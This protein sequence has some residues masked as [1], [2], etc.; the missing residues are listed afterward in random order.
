MT[1]EEQLKLYNA[2]KEAYYNNGEEI[3][4]DIEFDMLEKEL[5]LEN[6]AYVGARHNP[7][8]TVHH[9]FVMGSLSKV[10]IHEKNDIVDWRKYYNEVAGFVTKFNKDPQLIITPKYDG[11]SFELYINVDYSKITISTRGDGEFGRDIYDHIINKIPQSL[12]SLNYSEYVLRGEVLVNKSIFE[13]KYADQFTNP[14]SFVAGV[15]GRDYSDSLE[16]KDMLSDLDIVIYDYRT[17]SFKD[18]EWIDKDWTEL[19][20]LN[21]V[22]KV[23]PKFYVITNLCT[24]DDENELALLYK[25]FEEHRKNSEYALDGFVIKP[26]SSARKLNLTEARPKDCVAIKFIPMLEETEVINITWNLGKTGEYIP[27]IWVNP[28]EMDGRIVQ[29]CSGHNYGLLVKQGVGIG[30]KIIMSLAGDIIPFLYKVTETHIPLNIPMPEKYTIDGVHMMAILDENDIKRN[31]F[32][33]SAA[34]LNIPNLGTEI[35]SKVFDSFVAEDKETDEFF[36]ETAE[37]HI[38]SNILECTPEELFFAVKN[39]SKNKSERNA[40]KIT[41]DF[42]K[43]L[44]TLS[45]KEIIRSFNFKFCGDKVAEQVTNYLLGLDYDFTSMASEGYQWAMNTKSDNYSKLVELIKKLGKEIDDFKQHAV[46]TKNTDADKIPVILTGEPN[47]YKSKAEFI[48]HNPQYR[49]TGSWKEVKI[50]FTNDLESNTGKMK[51]AREKGIEIRV[52]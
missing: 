7:S 46:E 22:K 34:S 10:Q 20:N 1:H 31:S 14:R 5:G 21:D 41:N 27:I 39:L 32:V 25:K 43:I 48:Q 2:A 23:L 11:C 12:L 45:L 49:V 36:G 19:V 40:K 52:Y 17:K 47:N 37:K 51:K 30:S 33:N 3:M 26:I 38:P 28:V 6:K 4:S 44:E 24:V 50:V 16:F 9:P 13:K 18:D 42:K 29:K 35:A 8:Y 15:L